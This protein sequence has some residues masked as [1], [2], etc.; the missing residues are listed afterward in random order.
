MTGDHCR[1]RERLNIGRAMN[2][3]RRRTFPF[4]VLRPS[5]R[6]AGLSRQN[7]LTLPAEQYMGN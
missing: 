3:R 1:N 4:G 7:L 6:F 2:S 5:R